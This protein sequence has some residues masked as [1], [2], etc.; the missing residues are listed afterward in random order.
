MRND[1]QHLKAVDKYLAQVGQ[2]E[3]DDCKIIQKEEMK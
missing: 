2:T 3:N 1:R